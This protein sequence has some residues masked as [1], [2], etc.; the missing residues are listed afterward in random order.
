MDNQHLI[1]LVSR[2]SVAV[3]LIL[4]LTK[5][6]AVYV[7]QSLSV[8][9]SLFDS[10]LDMLASIGNLIAVTLSSRPADNKFRFG[11]GKLEAVSALIQSLLIIVSLLFLVIEAL[12]RFFQTDLSIS[13]S[14]AGIAAM[15][16]SIIL[17]IALTAFQRYV[18]S[19]T[20]SLAIKADAL[21]YK[22]DLA[23]NVVVII[24]LYLSQYYPHTDSFGCLLIS[25]Y[26]V[27]STRIIIIES[28]AVLL[29]QEINS[30]DQKKIITILNNHP[31]VRGFHN[32]RTRTSGKRIFIEAH[33][34]MD[35]GLTLIEAHT[36][37]HELKDA[38]EA[39][40][41]NAEVMIH[42]DPSGYDN[43]LEKTF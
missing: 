29:D 10:S 31:N 7:T 3:A 27:W 40:Y 43:A 23:V 41:P 30:V 20:E 25:G 4:T 11:Y 16:I 18:I 24:S 14:N 6:Y 32:F 28:L 37:A 12:Q 1:K 36:I 22:T 42:Q 39:V 19:K 9:S 33:I 15:G 21:H 2:S 17:T 8:L 38:V 34:E 35:P 5:I 13:N 26:V